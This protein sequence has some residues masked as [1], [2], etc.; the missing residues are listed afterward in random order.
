M[1]TDKKKNYWRLNWYSAIVVAIIEMLC[2]AW[3]FFIRKAPT[4][5]TWGE[6]AAKYL[7]MWPVLTVIVWVIFYAVFMPWAGKLAEKEKEKLK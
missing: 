2:F 1:T 7:I 4:E 5:P 3:E 6:E